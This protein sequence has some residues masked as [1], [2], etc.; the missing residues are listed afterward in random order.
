MRRSRCPRQIRPRNENQDAEHKKQRLLEQRQVLG[1]NND[2]CAHERPGRNRGPQPHGEHGVAHGV[3]N[4]ERVPERNNQPR[5]RDE[6]VARRKNGRDNQLNV[7]VRRRWLSSR[8]GRRWLSSRPGRRWLSS[9]RSRRIE[10]IVLT[11]RYSG[12]AATRRTSLASGFDTATLW[13][14]QPAT[15]RTTRRR[16]ACLRSTP[17]DVGGVPIGVTCPRQGII[18]LFAHLARLSSER[19]NP[20]CNP[21][22]ADA[23]QT[24]RAGCVLRPRWGAER[25]FR[26]GP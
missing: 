10:T 17:R 18:I 8:P 6:Q 1:Q 23:M 15:R 20:R 9:R 13:P 19:P 12:Y 21:C 16:L 24:S 11:S 25:P 26:A 5:N 3:G 22:P 14:T 2:A 4:R 7:R